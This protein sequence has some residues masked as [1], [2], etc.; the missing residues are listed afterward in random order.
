MATTKHKYID[1]PVITP[2][3]LAQLAKI[4]DTITEKEAEIETLMTKADNL[5]KK[6][7]IEECR[8][9]GCMHAKGCR[10]QCVVRGSCC[11]SK[12]AHGGCKDMFQ[13]ESK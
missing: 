13:R 3:V 6:C 5:V 9:M 12:W 8:A 11:R 10:L 2:D 1:P 4:H 7:T